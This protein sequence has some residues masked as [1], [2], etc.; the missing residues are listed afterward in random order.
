MF[1]LAMAN[2]SIRQFFSVGLREI[3]CLF[4][5]R[6]VDGLEMDDVSRPEVGQLRQRLFIEHHDRRLPNLADN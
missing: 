3:V 1:V 2:P 6:E 4:V 5:C